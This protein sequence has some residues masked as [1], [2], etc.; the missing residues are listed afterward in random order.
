MPTS[1]SGMTFITGPK[2]TKGECC[3]QI[4]QGP[5]PPCGRPF[6]VA[7]ASTVAPATERSD[8]CTDERSAAWPPSSAARAQL[9][10]AWLADAA[11]EH[12]SVASFA[13][14][15]LELLAFGAPPELVR[16]AHEAALD[17]VEHAR[18]AYGI[19]SALGEHDVG[20]AP[21]PAARHADL[22]TSVGDLVR[23]TVRDG[24]VGETFAA[25]VA[26]E[27]HAACI[28]PR[29][30]EVLARIAEDERSHAAYAFRVVAWAIVAFGD[31]ARG[32]AAEAFTVAIARLREEPRSEPLSAADL[33]P[34]GRLAS[35]TLDRLAASTASEVLAPVISTLLGAPPLRSARGAGA[36][37]V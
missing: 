8:W 11:M 18:L 17:E 21:F 6:V 10:Q 31:E 20:P 1:C 16:G 14:L 37:F 35:A 29:S 33:G 30:R 26:A 13:R 23:A 5:V 32:A 15:A 34:Y 25:L 2:R 4:C 36:A 3:Y 12:A 7:G 9:R 19:A 22:A 28:E 27:A 24:C